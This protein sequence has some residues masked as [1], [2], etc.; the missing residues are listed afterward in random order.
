MDG[1]RS[2]ARNCVIITTLVM[3]CIVI[4]FVKALVCVVKAFLCVAKKLCAYVQGE[5]DLFNEI[6]EDNQI[7]TWDKGG[8][9]V[10]FRKGEDQR[11]RRQESNILRPTTENEVKATIVA[12]INSGIAM[13][14]TTKRPLI[15][16]RLLRDL[17]LGK[18]CDPLYEFILEL[19]VKVIFLLSITVHTVPRS[20][21]LCQ[22]LTI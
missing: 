6:Y 17:L 8:L 18:S 15:E 14:S 7:L 11:D 13:T 2:I 4:A 10:A 20:M 21:L 5:L 9:F 3:P 19:L 12:R 22:I 1:E 16:E